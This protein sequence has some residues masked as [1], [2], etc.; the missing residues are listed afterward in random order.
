[1]LRQTLALG[2]AVLSLAACSATDSSSDTSA[3]VAGF[4]LTLTNCGETV[5]VS[6]PP[7]RIVALNQG[8]TEVLLSLGLA[9]RMAGTATWTDPVLDSLTAANAKVPRLADNQP[10]F[11]SVLGADPDLVTGSF[12]G[13]LGKGGVASRERFGEMGVP[14]YLAPTDCEASGDGDRSA[15][16]T[17]DTVYQEID[18]LARLTGTGPAGADLVADLKKKVDDA[19]GSVRADGVTAAFW[20]ANAESPYLAGCCGAPGIIST[21]LGLKN[22]FDDTHAEWPQINW[23]E[24]ASRNPQVLVLGDLTRKSQT[25]ESGAAKI[26]FLEANP[27]TREMD[28]VK[29]KRYILVTGAEMNPSI[30]TVYG[31]ENVAAGLE[32]LG[33]GG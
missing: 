22:V 29:N 14:T 9:D 24:F 21:A 8:S 4:P 3:A 2:C 26:A 15:P 33:L 16:V 13:T 19:T 11:E 31:I 6:E 7:E 10:S 12:A 27:V 18:D 25:A 30:R 20:F 1:M 17:L 32:R 23:E 28:A 5:T